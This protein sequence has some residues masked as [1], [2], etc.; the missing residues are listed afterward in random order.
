MCNVRSLAVVVLAACH[1]CELSD[2]LVSFDSVKKSNPLP[3][4]VS[5]VHAPH[6]LGLP[7][8]V[9][10]LDL[11][12][13]LARRCQKIRVGRHPA[14]PRWPHVR[15]QCAPG[16]SSFQHAWLVVTATRRLVAP[17]LRTGTLNMPGQCSLVE[18]PWKLPKLQGQGWGLNEVSM[19]QR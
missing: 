14:A 18:Q 2:T 6:A 15:Y 19:A 10:L 3:L 16:V 12:H 7:P 11:P 5:V 4:P 17:Q 13:L 9:L 1:A 8:A